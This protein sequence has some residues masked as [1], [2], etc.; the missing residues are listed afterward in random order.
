[1]YRL[2]Y[3][4]LY[5]T[6]QHLLNVLVQIANKVGNKKKPSA[7]KISRARNQNMAASRKIIDLNNNL[8]REIAINEQIR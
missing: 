4:P 8:T 5:M 7:S 1:M 2:H 3:M 6:L